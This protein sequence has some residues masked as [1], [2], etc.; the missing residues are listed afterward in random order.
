MCRHCW[1]EE[2]G[3]VRLDNEKVRAAALLVQAL[4]E[5]QPSGGAAHI[6]TDDWNL[7]DSSIDWC[8]E[9]FSADDFDDGSRSIPVLRAF[10]DM[11]LDERASALFMARDGRENL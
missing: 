6:V 3:G 4:D 11:T 10:K 8:L 5:E 1:E 7:E 9:N 2:Y